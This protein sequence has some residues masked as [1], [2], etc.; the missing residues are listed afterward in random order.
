MEWWVTKLCQALLSQNSG[1]Y[2]GQ[3]NPKQI[4][5]GGGG[6]QHLNLVHRSSDNFYDA[7]AAAAALKHKKQDTLVMSYLD[8]SQLSPRTLYERES[9]IENPM[10][11]LLTTP[12]TPS[13]LHEFG[14]R[15]VADMLREDRWVG[16]VI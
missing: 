5:G 4:P 2:P 13:K 3:M 1:Q 14:S 12:K 15:G 6:M 10:Q 9:I 16:V 7:K 11:A 8:D